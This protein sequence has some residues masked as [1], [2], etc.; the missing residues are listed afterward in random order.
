MVR[1]VVRIA[2]S[3]DTAPQWVLDAVV[4][5]GA[6]LVA[7]AEA[8]GLVWFDALRP[9]GLPPVLAAAP[10]ARW[11]HLPW[12]GVEPYAGILDHDR[13]WTCGKGVY[14]EPV[15]EHAMLL[16]VAGLRDL[17]R[18]VRAR[19]WERSGGTSLYDRPVTI[20]G[21]GGIT[22]ELLRHL[23]VFRCEVTVVRRRPE[24]LAG[25]ARVV[26]VDRLHEA[27]PGAQVVFIALALTPATTGIIGAAE[28]A[29]MDPTAWLVNVGRGGHV[30]T[31][32][33]VAALRAGTI[34]GAALDVTDPEPL[35]DGHPLWDLPNC[36]ITPHTANT[37][38]MARPA[39]EQRIT[40][41]VRRFAAGEPLVGVV[42]VA[43]GY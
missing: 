42:D 13:L 21:G 33:L 2:V 34:A 1:V 37:V 27:L 35:P 31:D 4:A 28:L 18:R 11:V 36:L 16:A 15:A 5:G 40:G 9:D 41:N 22:E 26:T 39:I 8:E 24:P 23:A 14:A 32:D 38:A 43:A 19:T 25:A 17:P 30:V 29:L 10:G 20:L 3:P 6:T 7:P 12:A